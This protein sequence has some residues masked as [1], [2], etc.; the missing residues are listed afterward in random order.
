MKANVKAT[1]R[2]QQGKDCRNWVEVLDLRAQGDGDQFL[3]AAIYR[4]LFLPQ[5]AS[6]KLLE[7]LTEDSERC[8]ADHKR[9]SR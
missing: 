5:L 2:P 3:L 6:T 7:A 1:K 8:E 4:A 9:G